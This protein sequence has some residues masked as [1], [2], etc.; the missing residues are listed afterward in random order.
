MSKEELLYLEEMINE[1]ILEYLQSGY[2]IDNEYIITLRNMLKK[3]GLKE[4]YNFDK[5]K[6]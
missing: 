3:L 2:S 1:E 5:Y 4:V 6:K